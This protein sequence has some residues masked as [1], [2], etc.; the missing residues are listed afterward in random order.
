MSEKDNV[1]ENN[2][3]I[4]IVESTEQNSSQT[5]STNNTVE[6]LAKKYG[7]N[8]EGE[9]SAEEFIE[10]A[11]REVPERGKELKRIKKTVDDLKVHM[12]KQ[13][14]YAYKQAIRDLQIRKQEAMDEGNHVALKQLEQEEK[15]LQPPD[16][17][18][19]AVIDFEER[20]ADWLDVSNFETLEMRE[21]AF[22][23]DRELALKNY[24]PEKH[25]EILENELHK[26]FSNYFGDSQSNKTQLVESDSYSN[27][28]TSTKK[29]N[30]KPTFETLPKEYRD[31][32]ENF[33]R[34]GIM[35][36]QQ[37]LEDLIKHGEI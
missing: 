34:M 23:R 30:K 6:L 8:P 18:P 11:L 27:V 16:E 1:V 21:W 5:T 32:G 13:Q 24:T 3:N 4:E 37:Y 12:Q 26:K 14:E 7:W 36:K 9:K 17:R 25:M 20:N 19:Q 10:F 35:T 33:E 15:Y 31:I 22:K 29:S 2:N 28:V